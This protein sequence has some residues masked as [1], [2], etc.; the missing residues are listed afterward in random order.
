ME[1]VG[2]AKLHTHYGMMDWWYL[3]LLEHDFRTHWLRWLH[4]YDNVVD[5]L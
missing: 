4:L 2:T 1:L 5:L 3:S